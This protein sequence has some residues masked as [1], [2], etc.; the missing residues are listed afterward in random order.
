M[1][2]KHHPLP[3]SL[4]YLQAFV[5]ALAKVS[6]DERNEDFDSAAL[7][8][9]L[10]K[11][12]HGFDEMAATAELARDRALLEAWLKASAGPDHP[13]YWVLGFLS[14]PDLATH[15]LQPAI[16]PPP[17]PV[18]SFDA[19]EGWKVKVVSSRLDLKKGKLTGSIMAI[20]EW[21]FQTMQR[22][23]EYWPPGVPLSRATTEVRLGDC[24]GKKYLFREPFKR[25]EYLLAVPGGFVSAML[26]ALGA[27][28]DEAPFES[29]FPT[30]KVSRS[31]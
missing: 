18:I 12:V 22:Q 8:Q 31:A 6:P 1:P 19:P 29:R 3:D 5:D 26:S 10:R 14:S 2:M 7:E 9:A 20:D 23:E 28:F 4:H 21:S 15:L 27:D 25:V 16:P 13:A 24:A 30:L 11:R 17:P